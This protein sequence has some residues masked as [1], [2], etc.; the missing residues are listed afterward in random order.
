MGGCCRRAGTLL[1]SCVLLAAEA[2]GRQG[3]Q[4]VSPH[5][6]ATLKPKLVLANEI[7]APFDVV[8]VGVKSYSIGGGNR[9]FAPAVGG[10]TFLCSMA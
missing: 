3:L 7:S 5:G 9:D 10:D 1:F 6:N 4:I 2:L 8:L